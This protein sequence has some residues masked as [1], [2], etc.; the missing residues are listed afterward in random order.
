MTGIRAVLAR[1]GSSRGLILHRDE[2]ERIPQSSR[3][4]VIARLVGS[5]DPTGRQVDGVGGGN[6]STSKV[7]V[8][9]P[10]ERSGCDLDYEF[11]QVEVATGAIERRGTCGNLTTAVGQYA[12]HE[13]LVPVEEPATTVRLND[14]N[15]GQVIHVVVPV[16]QG[17]VRYDGDAVTAGVPGSGAAVGSRF[18][19][20]GGA[21]SGRM[22]PTGEARDE[23]P[24]GG[25][26]LAVTLIDVVSPVALIHADSFSTPPP[27]DPGAIAADSR[28]LSTMEQVRRWAAVACGMASALE[29]AGTQS[30]VL[31]FVGYFWDAAMRPVEGTPTPVDG[32]AT[33]RMLSGGLLHGALPLGAALATAAAV[34]L[35]GGGTDAGGDVRTVGLRHASG[36]LSIDTACPAGADAA[37]DTDVAALIDWVGVAQTGRRIMAGELSIAEL[38]L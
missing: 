9:G 13:R 10:S 32:G 26:R 34:R 21:V 12:V 25:D 11:Y 17:E 4:K 1:G 5:P 22:Y 38:T 18:L 8:V 16:E 24:V 27:W 15:T 28:L 36:V 31:P 14:V 3:H 35:R 7:A 6:V 29:H 37:V 20:P 23:I 33:V 30:P 19:R 2:L